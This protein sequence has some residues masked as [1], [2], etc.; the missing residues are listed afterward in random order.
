MAD[1]KKTQSQQGGEAAIA[2]GDDGPPE[3]EASTPGPS[4]SRPRATS[5]HNE[6]PTLNDPFNFPQSSGL[7]PYSEAARIVKPVAIPQLRPDAAAPFLDA[8]SPTLTSRGITPETWYSFIKTMSAFL[9]A[10]VSDKAVAHA[11]DMA[12]QLGSGPR[13]FGKG[14]ARNAKSVSQHIK[15]NAKRGDVL[16]TAVGVVGG[17]ISL[18]VGT[19]LSAVGTIVSL[20]AS[21]VGAVARKPQTPVE[22]AAAYAAVA[23]KD[24]LNSRGLYA[25]ILDTQQLCRLIGMSDPRQLIESASD[26]KA[27]GAAGR[28]KLLSQYLCELQLK[29]DGELELGVS[30]LWLVVN[31]VSQ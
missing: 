28:V 4:S 8:Y 26:G 7:P 27:E 3:Y 24:W 9:T 20:P 25:Q 6:G 21:A 30:T 29:D 23:N 2:A 17:A 10:K 22:R 11:G 5:D 1:A 14:V 19:A 16:G 13:S 18:T 31:Q 15:S 12:R